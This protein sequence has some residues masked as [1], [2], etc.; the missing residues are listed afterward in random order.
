METG[1]AGPGGASLGGAGA[2]VGDGSTFVTAYEVLEGASLEA[3]ADDEG[4]ALGNSVDVGCALG[5]AEGADSELLDATDDTA[6]ADEEGATDDTRACEDDGEAEDT[7]DVF[8][9]TDEGDGGTVVYCV[10][11][12]TGGTCSDVDGRSSASG[13]SVEEADTAGIELTTELEARIE[14]T[15]VLGSRAAEDEEL[16]EDN[17]SEVA[18]VGKTVVYSVLVTTRRDEAGV[19]VFD[20]GSND[21][22]IG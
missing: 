5:V 8:S 20:G 18:G 4:A 15:S 6:G 9:G 17:T 13:D 14:V 22:S 16:A 12:T 10:T 19:V 11:M 2:S 7:A 1:G 3:S 21:D